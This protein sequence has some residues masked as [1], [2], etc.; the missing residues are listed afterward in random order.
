MSDPTIFA[1]LSANNRHCTIRYTITTRYELRYGVVYSRNRFS[2]RGG[3]RAY[4]MIIY[5]VHGLT[6]T[7][8]RNTG[9]AAATPKSAVRREILMSRS[10]TNSPDIVTRPYERDGVFSLLLTIITHSFFS[11][12]HRPNRYNPPSAKRVYVYIIMYYYALSFVSLCALSPTD[13][14]L[15]GYTRAVRLLRRDLETGTRS[16]AR[17]SEFAICLQ[18]KTDVIVCNK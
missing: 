12:R 14:F 10:S 15:S 1:N 17:K 6:A 8:N 4:N 3:G 2:R 18:H 9:N 7:A 16:T 11:K 13:Q 5:R